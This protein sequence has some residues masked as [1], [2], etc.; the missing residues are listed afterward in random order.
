MQ[1]CIPKLVVN[2]WHDKWKKLMLLYCLHALIQ[3]TGC[4]FLSAVSLFCY[5]QFLTCF[6]DSRG[7][8]GAG[9]WAPAHS[10]WLIAS[11]V[12]CFS[13][14]LYR[15]GYVHFLNSGLWLRSAFLSQCNTFREE[16]VADMQVQL[17]YCFTYRFT[18]YTVSICEGLQSLYCHSCLTDKNIC[19]QKMNKFN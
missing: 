19:Q 9:R 8:R 11:A 12:H 2:L 18:G 10:L 3:S 15:R 17:M 1:L 16:R 4:F 5:L 7:L 13:M 6:A 14:S